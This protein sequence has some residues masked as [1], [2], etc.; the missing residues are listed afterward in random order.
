MDHMDNLTFSFNQL[1][2]FSQA[3]ANLAEVIDKAKSRQFMVV[4]KRQKPAIALIETNYLAKL[5]AVYKQWQRQREFE[6]I[7]NLAPRENVTENQVM[8]DA[9]EAVISVRKKIK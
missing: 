6:A 1:V 9:N 3:R 7:M 8:I 2:P 5:I 4:T